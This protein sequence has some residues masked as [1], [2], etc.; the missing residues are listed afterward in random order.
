MN[1][2]VVDSMSSG[3]ECRCYAHIYRYK[4][5]LRVYKTS[6]MYLKF[7]DTRMCWNGLRKLRN[8]EGTTN[9]EIV[10]SSTRRDKFFNV[11]RRCYCW[12]VSEQSSLVGKM[13]ESKGGREWC[14]WVRMRTKTTWWGHSGP[15]L[16][17]V[18]DSL[19]ELLLGDIRKTSQP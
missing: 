15:N 14:E 9:R 8:L 11:Y 19:H 4:L 16:G 6:I 12:W 10:R 2:V 7:S 1:F 5:K 3:C 13:G 17:G 18:S